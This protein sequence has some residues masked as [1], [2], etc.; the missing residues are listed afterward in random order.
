MVDTVP[1]LVPRPMGRSI[2][3]LGF[4]LPGVREVNAQIVPYTQWWD[5]QNQEAVKADGPLLVAVGDS[6]A[7]GIGATSPDRSYVGLLRRDLSARDG[8]PWRV[9]NLA[10]SGARLDDALDRQLPA[11]ASLLALSPDLVTCCI[12]S[13]DLV[14][15]RETTGLRDRLRRVVA[16]LPPQS[17][18]GSLGGSSARG[19]LAN[20]ALRNATAEREIPLV[21]TWS[22]FGSHP[23]KRMA[24]DRFHPNDLGYEL[25]S[26]PFGRELGLS[27]PAPP[28]TESDS[29]PDSDG[30]ER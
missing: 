22:E 27:Y 4:L 11:L 2:K 1:R 12:G 24:A 15:G 20:R 14:W 17:L 6:T 7:V 3:A 30:S 10:I 26:R 13:N 25:M 28:A 18:V 5:D 16:E 21:S 19:Q 29:V 9:I 8:Q 23:G